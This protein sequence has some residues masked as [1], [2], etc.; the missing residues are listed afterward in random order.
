M[1]VLTKQRVEVSV[2]V[3]E[4]SV[5]YMANTLFQM[6]FRVAKDRGLPAELIVRNR[7]SLERGFFTW[8]AEQSLLSLHFEIVAPD[9]SKALERWDVS[10]DYSA[11][12]DLEVRKPPVE[13]IGDVCRRLRALPPGTWYRLIVHTKPDASKVDGWT[14]TTFKPFTASREE[15]L[16]GWGFG[17]IGGKAFCREGTW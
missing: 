8:L 4:K 1:A 13:E 9:G 5:T 15:A 6:A 7:D 16:P 14:P 2:N 17:H 10:F 12:P 3:M 11:D